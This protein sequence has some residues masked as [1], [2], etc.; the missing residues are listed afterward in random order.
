MDRKRCPFMFPCHF[1]FLLFTSMHGSK[2][3]SLIEEFIVIL[4][5]NF[6]LNSGPRITMKNVHP[7][8]KSLIEAVGYSRSMW[9]LDGK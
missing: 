7:K 4:V 2:V 6:S 1:T 8:L 9:I 5:G 3:L